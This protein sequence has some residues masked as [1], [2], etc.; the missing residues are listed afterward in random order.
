MT[1]RLP[2]DPAGPTP[3]KPADAILRR[4]NDFRRYEC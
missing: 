4:M 3:A 2:H 1:R